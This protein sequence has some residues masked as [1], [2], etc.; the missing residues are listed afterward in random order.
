MGPLQAVILAPLFQTG[1]NLTLAVEG[2]EELVHFDYE[3][4]GG[5]LGP[6][7][8]YEDGLGPGIVNFLRNC[9]VW[10]KNITWFKLRICFVVD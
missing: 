8:D 2:V 5:D 7:V 4:I 3:V 1:Y 6:L 9:S 10:N